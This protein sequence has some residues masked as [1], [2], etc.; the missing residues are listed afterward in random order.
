MFAE[1]L[2]K[3]SLADI[4][5]DGVLFPPATDR[6]FWSRADGEVFI[7]RAEEL[8]D[9]DWPTILATDF[10]AFNRTGD[11]DIMEDKHFAR[12]RAFCAFVLAEICEGK[13]R[14]TDQVINGAMAICEETFWGVSAHYIGEARMIPDALDPYVDLFAAE[15]GAAIAI[16]RY[17][18]G[19]QMAAVTPEI[20]ERLDFELN[21]RILRPFLTHNDFWWMGLTGRHVNNWNPWIISNVITVAL[22]AEADEATKR[23]VLEKALRLMDNYMAVVP[24]DG[25]CDEG[26]IYW[27]VSAGAVFDALFQLHMASRGRI[28]FFSEPLIYKMGDYACKAYIGDGRVVNLAD[29]AN[30]VE[31][32]GFAHGM[33]YHFGR[34]TNNPRLMGL[35]WSFRGATGKEQAMRRAL[36]ALAYPAEEAT[37]EPYPEAV[38]EH[39]EVSFVRSQS[40]FGAVKGGHNAENHNHNDVGS[41]LIY[42][43]D[44]KPLFVDAGVGVYTKDTFSSNRYKI[45][46]MQSSWHNLPDLNG[47]AQPAGESF[48]S[49]SFS[50]AGGVTQVDFAPAYPVEAGIAQAKR[51]FAVADDAV[52]IT[53]AF[54]FAGD[55]NTIEEHFLLAQE[56]EVHDG[57]VLLGDF[58]F[59]FA[60]ARVTV[61]AEEKDI[62]YDA[63]LFGAWRQNSLWRLTVKATTEKTATLTFTLKRRSDI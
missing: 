55:T 2:E 34:M 14:F 54:V 27:N 43:S 35:G 3:N 17:M 20:V 39:L 24:A 37:F 1:W 48:R 52:T 61:A 13:G 58:L 49:A 26:I 41:F 22:L 28:D 30:R 25:G 36:T 63:R 21:R 10:M 45:W 12:R 46:S 19:A 57:Y 7:K 59:T 47:M 23:A 62:S 18:L 29:G 42:T 4:K 32:P 15:T 56:P 16:C 50:Y 31:I 44:S 11:R 60:G 53:D 40:F 8:S 6:A 33:I 38:L 51:T 5:L 9:F